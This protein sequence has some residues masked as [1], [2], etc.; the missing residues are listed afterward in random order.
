MKRLVPLLLLLAL[1]VAA[2]HKEPT[3]PAPAGASLVGTEWLYSKT[4][5]LWSDADYMVL[6]NN[7]ILSFADTVSGTLAVEVAYLMDGTS[8]PA[9]TERS[10]FAY[11]FDGHEGTLTSQTLQG[12]WALS[13]PAPNTLRLPMESVHLDFSQ[14]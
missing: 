11:S 8:Y 10:P 4:D 2:C 1:A 7:F 12:T 5:T 14:R 3:D 13:L 6:Y 9:Q